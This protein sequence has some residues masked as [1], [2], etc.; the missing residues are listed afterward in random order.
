MC[1]CYV[2]TRGNCSL[3]WTSELWM[4]FQAHPPPV[5]WSL[6]DGPR[7]FPSPPRDKGLS[8]ARGDWQAGTAPSL[9]LL[10]PGSYVS[11][12]AGHS[13]S[14]GDGRVCADS[15]VLQILFFPF[16]GIEE[17][18]RGPCQLCGG[19]CGNSACPQGGGESAKFTGRG[20]NTGPGAHGASGSR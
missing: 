4:V 15:W 16:K 11:R 6:R 12:A 7:A 1:V 17:H 5:L 20:F 2:N 3:L 19:A 14:R 18:G 13:A 8:V 10:E 9:F